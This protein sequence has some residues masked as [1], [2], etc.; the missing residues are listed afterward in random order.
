ME[1]SEPVASSRV[2]TRDADGGRIT[3]GPAVLSAP[4]SDQ[5]KE[6]AMERFNSSMPTTS[7]LDRLLDPLGILLNGF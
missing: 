2:E 5:R 7:C 1:R 3:S 6:Q 4:G